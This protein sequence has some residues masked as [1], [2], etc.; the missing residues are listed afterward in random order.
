[1]ILKK[2][3]KVVYVI[4]IIVSLLLGFTALMY[5]R[6]YIGYVS[7]SLNATAGYVHEIEISVAYDVAGWAGYYGTAIFSPRNPRTDWPSL[8]IGGG[9]DRYDFFFSC[10]GKTGYDIWA[11]TVNQT[12][13]NLTSVRNATAEDIDNFIGITSNVSFS[14]DDTF[15]DNTSV[16]LG[17]VFYHGVTAVRTL[18]LSSN[19]SMAAF[20]DANDVL[21]FSVN[22]SQYKLG[23]NNIYYNYQM[24]LPV[25]AHLD[26]YG[27]WVPD[28]VTYYFFPD[29]VSDIMGNCTTWEKGIIAGYV[30]D[31]RDNSSL[32]NVTIHIGG[33]VV[34]TDDEGYYTALLNT[35][36]QLFFADKSGYR[37][38]TGNATI[39]LGETTW[40]NFSMVPDYGQEI[41]NALIKGY[42]FK[43]T[44]QCITNFTLENC[45]IVN[46]TVAAGGGSATTNSTG[47]YSFPI[48]QGNHTI[49][50]IHSDYL[51]Y[52]GN[53]SIGL[54]DIKRFN[55]TMALL[56]DEGSVTADAYL[57][58]Y[59][60]DR[61]DNSTI[62]NVSVAAGGSSGFTNSAG[63]YKIPVSSGNVTIMA[64]KEGYAAYLGYE[65]VDSEETV[66]H[67]ITISPLIGSGTAQDGVVYGYVNDNITG[68]AIENAIVA[69]NGSSGRTNATGFFNFTVN[70]GT[71]NLSAFAD[72]YEMYDT[73]ITVLPY[74]PYYLNIN[75]TRTIY[76][77]AN[78]TVTGNVFV[79]DSS[80]VIDNATIVIGRYV[81]YSNENGSFSIDV[82]EDDFYYVFG[83]KDGYFV[84]VGNL[85]GN[86]SVVAGET[87]NITIEM[88]SIP[89]SNPATQTKTEDYTQTDT[90]DAATSVDT[91]VEK[92]SPMEI[93]VSL[94]EIIKKIKRGSY[95]DE[96]L[97]I[98]NFRT[99]PIK[100]Q[101]DVEG[102]VAPSV[103]LGKEEIV[104]PPDST[105]S[106]KV[107]LLGNQD[108]GKYQGSIRIRGDYNYNIPVYLIITEDTDIPVRT[109]IMNLKPLNKIAY[110]GYDFKYE[111][112]LVNLLVGRN[113][114]VDLNFF[115]SDINKQNRTDIGE[116]ST[117][118]QTFASLIR[119]TEITK[120]FVP[121]DYILG[122]EANYLNMTSSTDT[123]FTVQYPLHQYRLFGFLP[124]WLLSL[125]IGF[126]AQ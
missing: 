27:H 119:T 67:N 50:S 63:Y 32:F 43:N 104:I 100:L 97:F 53:V 111:L 118:I 60:F 82:P 17:G 91:L 51:T 21:F 52:S 66:M 35:G 31:I 58:G 23:F 46:A 12:Q 80:E 70:A 99:Y 71:H 40:K 95:V 16:N 41:Y 42:V 88:E 109:L 74:V 4:I 62:A 96:E 26:D 69:A 79:K 68:L 116:Q 30:T 18:P 59:V 90:S 9:I 110:I 81:T 85:T 122:V 13:L 55:I 105:E 1:M 20:V 47:Q 37:T 54:Y 36:E 64:I 33:E 10:H 8:A 115:I 3:Y 102:T 103:H 72:E 14:G 117:N 65:F 114:D 39:Y 6:D 87:T 76:T 120:D 45:T 89:T 124:V 94:N 48:V 57:E 38:Y 84:F 125:I 49:I 75:L 98:Y 78:G 11:S 113:Y 5:L 15:N 25:P 2:H 121:G 61:R 126:I 106:I 7:Y 73:E 56:F 34:T 24:M 83:I 101:L 77:G 29:P 107:R 22:A 86:N 112:E 28:N 93:F 108:E 19:F 44:S 123:L 92:P